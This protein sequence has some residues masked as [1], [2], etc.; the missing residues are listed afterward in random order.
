MPEPEQPDP[1]VASEPAAPAT[2]EERTAV[3]T[4]SGPGR[5]LVAVYAVFA[6]GATARSVEQIAT[7]FSN[8]PLAF[9]LSGFAA[10]VYCVATYCL[11]RASSTNRR[12][13]GV[14]LVVET[15]GVLVVGTLSLTAPELFPEA[16]VWSDYGQGYLYIPVVLP[17]LGLLWLRRTG[18]TT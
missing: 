5:A 12:I 9:L 16:T 14:S 17:V 13:A 10:V 1:T 4:R 11:A 2:R 8:A 18:R 3:A 7:R 15:V 6:I